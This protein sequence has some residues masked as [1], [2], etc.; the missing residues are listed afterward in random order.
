MARRVWLGCLV[1]LVLLGALIGQA[2]ADEII[3]GRFGP[4]ALYRLV[5]PANWNGSLVVY[6]H[7][8]VFQI[9]PSRS[10]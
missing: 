2:R 8:Y 9:S 6:A 1:L 5:R 3:D 7:G 4:G 10:R